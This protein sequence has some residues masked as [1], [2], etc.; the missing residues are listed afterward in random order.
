ML[1]AVPYE[2]H[3]GTDSFGHLE[4]L[5]HVPRA[6]L[7]G[8]INKDDAIAGRFLHLLVFQEPGY[9]V[10]RGETSFLPQHFPAG[11]DGLGQGNHRPPGFGQSLADLLFERRF[12]G[13]GDTA[14][15]HHPVTGAENMADGGFL[16]VVEPVA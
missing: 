3:T 11:L 10:G 15:N 5:E 12:P 13:S 2:D 16:P 4:Q 1:P 7:A 6:E 9:R 8:L 14:D